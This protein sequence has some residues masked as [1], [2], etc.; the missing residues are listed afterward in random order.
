MRL[1]ECAENVNIQTK[2]KPQL[3]DNVQIYEERNAN[4]RLLKFIEIKLPI[5][6]KEFILNLDNDTQ[7]EKVCILLTKAQ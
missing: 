5:I 2:L 1:R 4:G 7:N 6:E 3:V